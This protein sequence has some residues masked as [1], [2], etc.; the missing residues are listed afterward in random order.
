MHSASTP[1]VQSRHVRGNSGTPSD[2]FRGRL[3]KPS[4]CRHASSTVVVSHG[5][6]RCRCLAAAIIGNTT[7]S[8]CTQLHAVVLIHEYI[9]HSLTSAFPQTTPQPWNSHTRF[10]TRDTSQT[11]LSGLSFASSVG[12]VRRKS[13][14]VST[15]ISNLISI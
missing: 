14:R 10:S 11:W 4:V 6:A 1:R 3:S 9:D 2:D 8:A 12:P 5:R 13:R 7:G 15:T